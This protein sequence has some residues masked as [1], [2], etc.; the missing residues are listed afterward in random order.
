MLIAYCNIV[1]FIVAH[2]VHSTALNTCLHLYLLTY[3]NKDSSLNVEEDSSA[4][5]Q[6]L[7]DNIRYICKL[8]GRR[9]AIEIYEGAHYTLFY[10]HISVERQAYYNSGINNN[11]GKYSCIC[12]AKTV[13]GI[14]VLT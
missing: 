2:R 3:G 10:L 14:H 4:L 9:V 8:F 7:R 6:R 11:Y 13:L 12:K 1:V 5:Q